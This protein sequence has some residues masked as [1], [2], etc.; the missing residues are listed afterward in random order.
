M[1]PRGPWFLAGLFLVTLATL[2][3]E[4]LDTRLLSVLTWYHLSFFAVSLA[5]FG[6]AGGAVHVYLR[7]G[8]FSGQA[9]PRALA[10]HALVLVWAIPASHVV[11]LC[12]PLRAELG[13]T[14][15]LAGALSTAA[16]AIPFYV[17][18]IVVATA[19]TRVPGPRGLIY[20]VDLLG[21]ALG[22]VL[23]V[24]ILGS[25][26]ISSAVL[27]CSALAAAGAACFARFADGPGRA[28]VVLALALLAAAFVN[29]LSSAGLRVI[30]PK[31]TPRLADVED[32]FWTIHGQV[33]VAS[34]K[35][36]IPK[37]WGPGRG[38]LQYRVE[39]RDLVIDGAAGTAMLR[40]GGDLQGLDWLAH[41]VTSL[42]YQLAPPGDV[43][44]IGVGGGRDL[45]TALWAGSDSVTG[46]EIN[47]A[48]LELLE[49]P[50]RDYAGIAGRD[51]VGL[52]HDEARSYLTRTPERFDLIQMSLIDTW[53]AT[54]AGAF[55]LSENG[56]YTLNGWRVVL[57]ALE[58]GGRFAVSRWS[59]ETIRLISLATAALHERG[60]ADVRPHLI[61]VR[62]G[63][64]VTLV[65]GLA[66]FDRAELRALDRVAER[67]AFEILLSPA[68]APSAPTLAGIVRSR[69]PREL[70]QAVQ[71]PL[72]DYTPPTDQRPY[73]F[74]VLKPRGLLSETVSLTAR[75]LRGNL[76][77][78]LT[79]ALLL[80]LALAG[81]IGVIGV[82]LWRSG[83]PRLD[84]ACFAHS[85][86]YFAC[87]GLG[88][89]LVQIPLVQR[90]SIYLG[91][92][93]YT[94][95]VIL[96]SMIL[97]TGIGSAL[98]DRIPVERDRRWLRAIPLGI[99][100]LVVLVTLALQPLI[101]A[102]IH[103]EL[104]AR[105]AIVAATVGLVGFP[106]GF[107]FPIGL[108][109]VQPLSE[110]ATPWMWG[111]NGAC[112]VL[113]S[114]SAVAISM[115]AG[116]DVGLYAAAMLYATT[117]V[118]AAYVWQRAHRAAAGS[119]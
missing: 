102:T 23:V 84:R 12:I 106:L 85:V 96:F 101:D 67:F 64:V 25:F 52:V 73:F 111:V 60:I 34:S 105:S 45:L 118:P 94:L 43:A 70:A 117:A 109:L 74:N 92:P 58:P 13:L 97:G 90:F 1:T 104:A 75:G 5:M 38:A 86:L 48:F 76:Q 59:T 54:G 63:G 99:A 88:F 42:P 95:A 77:A 11:N 91:H 17:A 24:P 66:P 81:V 79:L 40:W 28:P 55:T 4:L 103:L 115:W 61:L 71:D 68:V 44:V 32:E 3:L 50:L 39:Q 108:R 8:E 22:A 20:A 6:M 65:L 51:R 10:R 110:H 26:G 37:Y 14:Y 78:T 30:H 7:P 18:G 107:C 100:S 72:Y 2:M 16:L 119:T 21:A 93:T 31:G 53:A 47:S 36:G 9:T 98:S 35:P 56:L 29:D 80:G 87:I 82:P 114:V 69:T 89:M 49:G 41:D 113:A 116:I 62:G 112:S 57:D 19:L 27:V 46:I 15:V 83:L 33:T